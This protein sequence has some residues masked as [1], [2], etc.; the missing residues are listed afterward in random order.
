[1]WGVWRKR[2]WRTSDIVRTSSIDTA[3]NSAEDGAP[4][5]LRPFVPGMTAKFVGC[6]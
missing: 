2:A 5:K 6:R 1:M 3:A 4:D